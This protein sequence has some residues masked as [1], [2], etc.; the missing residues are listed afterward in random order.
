MSGDR[1]VQELL[2]EVERERQLEREEKRKAG[3]VLGDDDGDS[4]S[5]DY[6]GVTPL[7]EKL[8]KKKAK[9]LENIDQFWEP[10]DSESDDDERYSVEEVKKRV[11]AFEN[12]CKRFGELLKSFAE[13][14]CITFISLFTVISIFFSLFLRKEKKN[15]FSYMSLFNPSF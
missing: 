8:E 11:D 5:E 10:T 9:E 12:K 14:G 3:V 1:V 6:M 4:E 2:A 7:I 13:S 15:V